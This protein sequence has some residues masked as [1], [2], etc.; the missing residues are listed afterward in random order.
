MPSPHRPG[1]GDPF[2]R[3]CYVKVSAVAAC[4]FGPGKRRRWSSREPLLVEILEDKLP[5]GALVGQLRMRGGGNY[6]YL[7]RHCLQ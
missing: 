1:P 4:L 6:G 2:L 5:P 7:R 3:R